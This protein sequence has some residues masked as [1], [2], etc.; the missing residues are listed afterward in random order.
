MRQNELDRQIELLRMKNKIK[1]LE[2]CEGKGTSMVS[3]FVPPGNLLR[4]NKMLTEEVGV[5]ANIK[6]R[7]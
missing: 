5:S 6:S 2:S 3:L 4:A 1:E 7:V